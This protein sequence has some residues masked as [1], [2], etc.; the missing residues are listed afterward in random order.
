[1]AA[2]VPDPAAAAARLRELWMPAPLLVDAPGAPLDQPAA[3]IGI[4]DGNLALFRMPDDP[5]RTRAL[6]GQDFARPR[7]HA[8]ALRVRDLAAAEHALA[9]EKVR[10]L[11]GSARDGEL[12][13]DPA[14]THG[15]PLLW[16]D[17]DVPG[18]LRGPLV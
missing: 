11:R 16:T 4:P 15:I 13:T 17:R 3:V 6:W 5:A 8:F 7:L 10:V 12:Y 2:L 14:D 9:Q 1:M 18:D